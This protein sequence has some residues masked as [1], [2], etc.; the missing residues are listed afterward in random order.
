VE[1]AGQALG[2]SFTAT[3]AG[4]LKKHLKLMKPAAN[5]TWS[6]GDKAAPDH[7]YNWRLLLVWK[8]SLH[9]DVKSKF[10]A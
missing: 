2:V 1:G 5:C 9:I 6:A 8:L 7:L 3:G 4:G 10:L